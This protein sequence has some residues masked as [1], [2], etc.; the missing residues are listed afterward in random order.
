MPC[1]AHSSESLESERELLISNSDRWEK[2]K[3]KKKTGSTKHICICSKLNLGLFQPPSRLPACLHLSHFEISFSTHYLVLMIKSMQKL[4]RSSSL[5]LSLNF[6][7]VVLL[8][9]KH[10]SAVSLPCTVSDMLPQWLD[11]PENFRHIL[12][13]MLFDRSSLFCAFAHLSCWTRVCV[14]PCERV[15]V[16]CDSADRVL[17]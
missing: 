9:L 7:N 12:S 13:Q 15:V 6:C 5:W 10:V 1:Y 2:K 11:V 17:W 14:A 3:K 16:S 8:E 4:W